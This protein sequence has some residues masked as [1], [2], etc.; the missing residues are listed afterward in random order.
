MII[1]TLWLYSFLFVH[2]Y[3]CSVHY[4]SL[5]NYLFSRMNLFYVLLLV[6]FAILDSFVLVQYYFSFLLSCGSVSLMFWALPF[7]LLLLL[8]GI[9]ALHSSAALLKPQL[10]YASFSF[11]SLTISLFYPFPSSIPN[12]A[13]LFFLSITKSKAL[14]LSSSSNSS[15]FRVL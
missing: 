3:L 1:G 2:I 10:F 15:F 9:S 8:P 12:L 7:L 5:S 6:Y 11:F 14:V 13:F 4:I